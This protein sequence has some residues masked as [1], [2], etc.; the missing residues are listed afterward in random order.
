MSDNLQKFT[1]FVTYPGALSYDPNYR[2]RRKPPDR[3][4]WS[5]NW[6][7]DHGGPAGATGAIGQGV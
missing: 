2:N 6:R 3:G 1:N 5:G 4:D 7:P